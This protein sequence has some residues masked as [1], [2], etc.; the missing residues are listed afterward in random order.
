M[1]FPLKNSQHRLRDLFP[2]G[3]LFLR[4]LPFEEFF[5]RFSSAVVEPATVNA[6][7]FH[8]DSDRGETASVSF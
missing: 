5:L 4:D 3:L 8:V 2:D 6:S 7:I 1:Q